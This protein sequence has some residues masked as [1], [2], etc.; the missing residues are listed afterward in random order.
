MGGPAADARAICS[1]FG[2]CYSCLGRV[3]ARGRRSA[4]SLGRRLHTGPAAEC[5]VCRGLMDG[6]EGLVD[7]V[8]ERVSG[9]EYE[10]FS[11]GATLKVSVLD[12]DDYIRSRAGAAGA[13]SIK[14]ALTGEVGEIISGRTGKRLDRDDPDITILV[15]TRL[16]SCEVR[17]RH[18]VVGMRYTKTRRGLPQ[19]RT[20]CGACGGAGCD[21]CGFSGDGPSVEGVISAYLLGVVGGTDVRFTWVGGEDRDSLVLGS[22]RPVYARVRNPTRSADALP[23]SVSLDDICVYGMSQAAIPERLPP[24]KSEVRVV[25]RCGDMSNLR[26]VRGLAGL[27]RV[28][29]DSGRPSTR[30]VDMVRY[31]RVG[32]DSFR[33]TAEV[34]GGVPIKRLVSGEGV[35]PSVSSLLGTKCECM[36]FDFLDILA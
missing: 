5:Y 30:T 10:T 29:T 7:H 22:G 2:L 19:K 13:V 15:D 21:G 31:R 36:R 14:A 11:V 18:M 8:T 24:F 20:A 3:A 4:R 26:R 9:Y 1:E 33:M 12:R 28:G 32:D 6:L 27:V 23:E 16:G 25:V 17:S 34:E 35:E